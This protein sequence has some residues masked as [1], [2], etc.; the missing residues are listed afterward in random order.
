MRRD[1]E[2]AVAQLFL[3]AVHHR[4]DDNQSGN[5][6]RDPEHRYGGDERYEAVA[7]RAATGAEIAQ[8]DE[9]FVGN[10]LVVSK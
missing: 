7:A 1:R 9:Q 3:K 8:A 10:Q 2:D 5:A 4:D 6:E